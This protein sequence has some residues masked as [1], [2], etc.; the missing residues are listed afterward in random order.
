[1][2]T[3]YSLEYL[4]SPLSVPWLFGWTPPTDLHDKEIKWNAKE[5]EKFLNKQL[6]VAKENIKL[7]KVNNANDKKIESSGSAQVSQKEKG[8]PKNIMQ[9]PSQ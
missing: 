7:K 9:H 6:N 1:M 5:T 3:H 4:R 8:T 2:Y